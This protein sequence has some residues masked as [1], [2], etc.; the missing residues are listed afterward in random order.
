MSPLL[1]IN[2]VSA[3]ILAAAALRWGAGPE[4]TC[5][6]TFFAMTFGDAAYHA[7]VGLGP[8]YGSVDIWHLT[9]DLGAAVAFIGIAL[10][11]NR[12]YPLWLAAIQLISVI[13]HF[14]REVIE[15]LPKLAYGLMT[16]LPYYAIL[17]VAAGG[18]LVH[19]RRR[20]HHGPY[21][22]WRSSSSP[23]SAAAPTSPPIG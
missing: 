2:L 23:L 12:I 16:Y 20:K 8:V 18:L 10:R 6:A 7:L 13:S 5:A 17:F 9:I 22:P 15:R 14:A 3:A 11:A 21:R 4:R 19:A 1:T